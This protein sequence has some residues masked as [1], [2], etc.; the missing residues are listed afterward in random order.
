MS[1]PEIAMRI[2]LCDLVERLKRSEQMCKY[3]E[4]CRNELAK[5]LIRVKED[6]ELLQKEYTKLASSIESCEGI[7]ECRNYLINR[8]DNSTSTTANIQ[9]NGAAFSPRT[10]SL[11]APP[12]NEN[13]DKDENWEEITTR[14]LRELG[15]EVSKSKMRQQRSNST[16]QLESITQEDDVDDETTVTLGNNS[17]GSEL[18]VA[19]QP[20]NENTND[21]LKSTWDRKE[22]NE[23]NTEGTNENKNQIIPQGE[24]NILKPEEVD[25][26]FTLLKNFT[27]D[28]NRVTTAISSSNG[29][30]AK[31]RSRQLRM[32]FEKQL[33]ENGSKSSRC[34]LEHV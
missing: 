14:L 7:D 15:K 4:L 17:V 10:A 31:L 2:A 9:Q 5:E 6:N 28:I 12:V 29:K 3:L 24:N 16:Q 13:K 34:H 25:V 27:N 19:N 26:L 22:P 8:N 1:G 11:I 21:R 18:L 20:N 30:L 32:F 33:N 23:K